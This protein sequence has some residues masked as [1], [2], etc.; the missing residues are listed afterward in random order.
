VSGGGGGIGIG[1]GIGGQP[2]SIDPA[3][4]CLIL[5]CALLLFMVAAIHKVRDLRRF[6]AIFAAFSV[7][8]LAAGRRV[9]IAV[10]VLEIFVAGGLLFEGSRTLSLCVGIALLLA[11]ASV[12][13]LNLQRG[14][15]DLACGCGGPDDR[16]LIAPWM[17]WR[18]IACAIL[19]AAALLPW[20]VRLL[21]LTDAV[22][23]GFGTATCALVY[24]CLDR[25][26]G[27]TGRV[28]EELRAQ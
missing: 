8:P 27:R 16:R 25:L 21:E 3:I 12:I 20:S 11:Y 23:I 13:A 28:T 10:P 6:G 5:A 14:R 17:V 18:N 24:L 4:A 22:T 15:R 19:M 9:S 26:W 7:L 1:I 2:V